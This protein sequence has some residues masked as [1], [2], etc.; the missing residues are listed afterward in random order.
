ML[1]RALAQIKG[2]ADADEA[3]ESCMMALIRRRVI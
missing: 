2:G 1:G 3:L